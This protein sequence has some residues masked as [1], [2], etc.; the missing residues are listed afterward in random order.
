MLMNRIGPS[1]SEL[2]VA[3]ADGSDERKLFTTSGL[4]YHASYSPDGQWIVFTSE[5]DGL[6]QAEHLSR[7]SGRHRRGAADR[8]PRARRS[9]SA[10]PGRHTARVRLHAR[11][12]HRQHLDPRSSNAAASQPDRAAWPPGRSDQ[13]QWLLPARVV[14]GRQVDRL[15]LRPQHG[16]AGSQQRRRLGARA[17]AE[18]LRRAAG[19]HGPPPPDPARSLLGRAEVVR[20]TG[21]ASSSTRSRSSRPGRRTGRARMPRRRRR[22][23]RCTWSPASA[24]CTP[25]GAGLKVMP[26]FLTNDVDRL[27]RQGRADA[28]PRLHERGRP[29]RRRH[30]LA[31]RGRPTASTSSTRRSASV[32]GRRTCR[33]YSWDPDYE[34]RYTDVFP[35]FSKD[36]KLLL[37]RK[38]GDS[39]LDIMDPDGSNRQEVFPSNGGTAFSPS[40]S[41]DGQSIVFGYG[42]FLQSRKQP[43][44]IMMVRRDGTNLTALTEGTP[45]CRLPELVAGRH[46]RR[47]PRL[48]RRRPGTAHPQSGRSIGAGADHGL[49]QPPLLVSRWPAHRVHPAAQRLQLR[50]LHHPAGRLGPPAVD[51]VAGQRCPRRLDRRRH[52]TSCGTA[53]CTDGR[54]KRRCT[55]GRSSRTARSSS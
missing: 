12:A 22:S 23:C 45:E 8:Q 27:S 26:Q 9:G 1:S 21:R 46:A 51:H 55:T 20:R 30:A 42:G 17:G 18:H 33:L 52:G 14:A 2:Y 28:R 13:A 16:V 25:T 41:P 5:R 7:A 53:A 10:L 37:T 11:D 49:R 32:H 40:W 38:D 44:K 24:R 15:L 34:Y 50:R 43:A 31:R 19:R 29:R 54:K 3:Q 39:S 48:G 47:L 36:G 6:G 35:S 4:D